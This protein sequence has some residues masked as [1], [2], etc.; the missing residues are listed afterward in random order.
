MRTILLFLLGTL[1][2]AGCLDQINEHSQNASSNV[3]ASA[4][5][6]QNIAT[7]VTSAK[8]S[9]DKFSLWT[10]GTQLR[11]ANVY[12][13]RVYP[14][15]DSNI[16]PITGPFGPPLT[17]SDFDNLAKAGANVVVLSHPGIFDENSPYT[18]NKNVQ[19]NLDKLVG[20]AERA[21]LFVI[22]AFRTGPG[23]SEFSL[24]RDGAGVWYDKSYI[25]DDIWKQKAAQDA[26]A[27]MWKSAAAHYRNSSVVIGYDLMVEPNPDAVLD[28]YDP[29]YF[30]QKFENTTYDWNPLQTRISKAIRET[31]NST[32]IIVGGISYSM[33]NSLPYLKPNGDSCTVYEVHQYQPQEAYTHQKPEPS[34]NFPNTYPG[35]F[36]VYGTVIDFNKSWI[37][38][39]LGTVDLFRTKYGVPVAVTE[40]GAQR[41]EP[42]VD[43]FLDDETALFESRGMNHI[44]WA[45]STSNKTITDIQNNDFN[46]RFGPDPNNKQDTNSTLYDV[47]K[48]YWKQNTLRPSRFSRPG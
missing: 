29:A 5:I 12:Q 20:M 24:M 7:N 27:E 26:Y 8:L 42:G 11:G 2:L 17:Q 19:D 46:F 14:E 48:K 33:V 43:R 32:P 4:T 25:N 9:L 18:F 28:I 35:R 34:G 21:D 37:D 45:W 10:N 3:P 36:D 13:R 1:A 6:P 41:W 16:F 39:L 47:I 44:I 23:R 30:Y 15:L 40:Y 31:D 22:I 38:N